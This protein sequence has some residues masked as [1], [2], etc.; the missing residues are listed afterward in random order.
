MLDGTIYLS[1]RVIPANAVIDKINIRSSISVT[2]GTICVVDASTKTII[3]VIDAQLSGGMNSVVIEKKYTTNVILG[4]YNVKALWKTGTSLPIDYALNTDGCIYEVYTSE[5]PAIGDVL[6]PV[7]SSSGYFYVCVQFVYYIESGSTIDALRDAI[8]YENSGDTADVKYEKDEYFIFD[9]KLRKASTDIN[10]DDAITDSNSVITT[11]GKELTD[12]SEALSQVN[13]GFLIA[14][15]KEF[16]S[17]YD[18]VSSYTM[19]SAT[20][21][22]YFAQFVIPQ[23]SI[24]DEVIFASG[25]AGGGYVYIIDA[26]SKEVLDAISIAVQAGNQ[27]TSLTINRQYDTDVMIGFYGRNWKYKTTSS[28]DPAVYSRGLIEAK[29]LNSPPQVGDIL[30]ITTATSSSYAFALQV[31]Y[32]EK[33]FTSFESLKTS[34][35]KN[36]KVVQAC[37]KWLPIGLQIGNA[38]LRYITTDNLVEYV[39]RWYDMTVNNKPCKVTN[40]CGSEFYVEVDGANSC[41]LEWEPMTETNAYY[42][43]SIDGGQLVR[44]NITNGTIVL[45][46]AGVHIIRV[47]T[48]GITENIGKWANGTGFALAGVSV[49]SGTIKGALPMNPQIMFFGDSIVEGINALGTSADMGDTNSATGA[50]PWFCAEKLG[51]VSFRVGYGATGV[52]S[53]GSFHPAIDALNYLYSSLKV[54]DY[55]PDAIVIEHGTNDSSASSA[56]FIT[57]YEQFLDA[58]KVKYSGVRVYLFIPLNQTHAD[59]IR[60]ISNT[61]SWC[62]LIET[63]GWY[64]GGLH[65]SAEAAKTI[66]ERLADVLKADIYGLSN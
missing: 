45:P 27:Y 36:S 5:K 10:P 32:S 12:Q 20:R 39:G 64:S 66:G 21:S 26:A 61:Y 29:N 30:T 47:I 7:Y 1:D 62:K 41:I 14:E 24:I 58:I 25:A 42:A 50:F 22:I 19:D 60:T 34:T 33:V 13:E 57:A 17:L 3:D 46:D 4:F 44:V 48:D 49:D 23:N 54:P 56:S 35:E 51:T 6:S 40:N 11:V 43:Y 31:K 18:S 8:A 59:D 16:P 63:E 65:P 52:I 37:Q 15:N 28:D 55:Y 9:N 38:L 2:T 53:S